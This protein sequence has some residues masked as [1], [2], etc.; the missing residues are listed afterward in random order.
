VLQAVRKGRWKL[1]VVVSY[2]KTQ[3]PPGEGEPPLLFDVE[4]DISE[5][6]NQAARQPEVVKRLLE[7]VE[8]HR[9]SIAPGPP[10]R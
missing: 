8:S 3:P 2:R 1:H 4:R 9:A 7:V 6:R 5:R 10:Q